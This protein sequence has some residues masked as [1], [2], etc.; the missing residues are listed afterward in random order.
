[1]QVEILFPVS[2]S[3]SIDGLHQHWERG[4]LPWETYLQ[5]ACAASG[6]PYQ[7]MPEPLTNTDEG[8]KEENDEET[9][10]LEE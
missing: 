3:L 5:H 1:M 2:R 9:E 7:S 6:L 10:D 4:I 8:K